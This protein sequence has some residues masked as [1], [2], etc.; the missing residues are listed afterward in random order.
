MIN[1]IYYN[2]IINTYSK[3][4]KTFYNKCDIILINIYNSNKTF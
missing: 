4:Y 1:I 2:I 3:K